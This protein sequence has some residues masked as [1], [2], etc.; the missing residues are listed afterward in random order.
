MVLFSVKRGTYTFIL[1]KILVRQFWLIEQLGLTV[2][3]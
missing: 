3:Q 2:K 1:K